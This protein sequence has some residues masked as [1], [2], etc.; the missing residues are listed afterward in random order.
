MRDEYGDKIQN[1]KRYIAGEVKRPPER[2]RS[3]C[4]SCGTWQITPNLNEP[5][6]GCL[7]MD[8]ATR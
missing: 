7:A 3:R 5:C 2:K 4:V 6:R 8:R 1:R